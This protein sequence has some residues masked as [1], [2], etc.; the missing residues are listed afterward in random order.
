MLM[1]SI[2]FGH[3]YVSVIRGKRL[4]QCWEVEIFSWFSVAG[5]FRFRLNELRKKMEEEDD[6]KLTIMSFN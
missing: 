5:S 1:P 2:N 4:M 3:D 6:D